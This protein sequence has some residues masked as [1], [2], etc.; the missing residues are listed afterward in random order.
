MTAPPLSVLDLVPISSGSD[1][2]QALAN[3]VDLA[4]RTEAAGYLRYWVAEHHLNPGVAG[5]APALVI[6][7]LA[8]ATSTIRVGSG[9]V[10]MGHHTPLSVVEQF[11]I[12]DALHPGRTDLGLGR[13]GARRP[14]AGAGAPTDTAP[15][16]TD[17]GLLIPAPFSFAHLIGSPR[18]ALQRAQ[19]GRAHV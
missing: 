14:P 7:L 1:A 15:R 16:R 8:G 11:G 12:V 2:G 9:A 19:I 6:T 5:T 4:R 18:F 10:Q 13:S 3:S 17:E